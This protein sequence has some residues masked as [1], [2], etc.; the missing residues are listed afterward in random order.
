MK[1][2]VL[3]YSHAISIQDSCLKYNS[4]RQ[5]A[6]R[7]NSD[8]RSASSE[9]QINNEDQLSNGTTITE[10][11]ENNDEDHFLSHTTVITKVVEPSDPDEFYLESTLIT[12]SVENDDHDEI[13]I[14]GSHVELSESQLKSSLFDKEPCSNEST[15]ITKC[16]EPTDDEFSFH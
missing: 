16:V 6:V 8:P 3:S 13:R 11:I 5:I 9:E 4:E 1:P 14:L 7:S 2:Y 12:R 15:L 10:S